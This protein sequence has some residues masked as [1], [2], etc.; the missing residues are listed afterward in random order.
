MHQ[1]EFHR[2]LKKYLA[3]EASEEEK[4]VIDRWYDELG[5]GEFRFSD[6]RK[7]RDLSDEYW[8]NIATRLEPQRKYYSGHRFLRYALGMAAV[9]V[10]IF[11]S[12]LNLGY[13]H[14]S[15]ETGS[16]RTKHA[17]AAVRK[18]V[19]NGSQ[20][21]GI[22]LPDGSKVTLEPTST[23]EYRRAFQEATR[24]VYLEGEAFFEVVPDKTRPFEVYTQKLIT[25]VLGTSFTVVAY[26]EHREVTVSVR[27]GKVSVYPKEAS[28]GSMAAPIV[29]TPNQEF[30]Y[31][32]NDKKGS[33]NIIPAPR[34]LLP[35][36]E[37][38]RMRFEDA[39]PKVVFE[40][41][42]KVYGVDIRFDENKFSDCRLT[43]SISDGNIL[44]R[45]HIICEVMN[46]TYRMN[47]GKIFIEGGGC[48]SNR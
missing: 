26:R 21:E 15:S 23:L 9:G 37:A 31:D 8:Q 43:T 10:V 39:S 12:Y 46:A 25:K 6:E 5:N 11:V 29:L 2:I 13:P 44:S 35:Y 42:E 20:A 34:V 24:D 41:I 48:Q 18:I 19:N 14:R 16:L 17:I 38:K 45:L 32:K 22:V 27:S 33:R 40:A 1:D 36:D 47:D 28:G 7:A 3:G 30:V 4:R